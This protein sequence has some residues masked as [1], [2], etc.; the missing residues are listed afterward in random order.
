MFRGAS[1][2][3]NGCCQVQ[4][5]QFPTEDE[6]TQ[7]NE[8]MAHFLLTAPT[9]PLQVLEL[10]H[11]QVSHPKSPF[12]GINMQQPTSLAIRMNKSSASQNKQNVGE[13]RQRKRQLW[14]YKT[15][16]SFNITHH[17][18][19]KREEVQSQEKRRY[20]VRSNIYVH[21]QVPLNT[22]PHNSHSD[23]S[24]ETHRTHIVC[25]RTA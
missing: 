6:S 13:N 7:I 18:S 5:R 8:A 15:F 1:S 19:N 9:L 2:I 17:R 24:R 10:A 21:I 3:R 23:A 12:A 22:L 25:E 4:S 16:F 14:E 11:G 20:D